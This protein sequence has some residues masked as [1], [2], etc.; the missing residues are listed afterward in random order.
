MVA[1]AKRQRGKCRT[2]G[3][4]NVAQWHDVCQS[5][6]REIEKMIAD[7]K[8]TEAQAV[9]MGLWAERGKPGRPR[10]RLVEKVLSRKLVAAK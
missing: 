3:C 2:S 8:L 7:G 10:A 5:C 1:K 6:H 9:S 4:K